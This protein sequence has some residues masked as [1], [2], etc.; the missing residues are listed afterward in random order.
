MR[1]GYT[2][3]THGEHLQR[4]PAAFVFENVRVPTISLLYLFYEDELTIAW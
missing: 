2:H 4:T 3:R 1:R